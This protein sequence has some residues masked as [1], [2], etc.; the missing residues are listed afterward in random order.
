VLPVAPSARV[1]R[2][3]GKEAAWRRWGVEDLGRACP[4]QS[5]WQ[6][7][8]Q[9][10][11]ERRGESAHTEGSSSAVLGRAVSMSRSELESALS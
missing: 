7:G 2:P 5:G 1:K 11:D 10:R 8:A 6:P 9:A 4:S 3:W